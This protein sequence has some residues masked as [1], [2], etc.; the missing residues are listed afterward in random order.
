MSTIIFGYEIL[1]SLLH[2]FKTTYIMSSCGYFKFPLSR[3]HINLYNSFSPVK[4]L[5]TISRFL[6]SPYF[7]RLQTVGT[8][9]VSIRRNKTLIVYWF[10]V[11]Q[12]GGIMINFRQF[13]NSVKFEHKNLSSTSLDFKLSWIARWR[14]AFSLESIFSSIL[15]QQE[16]CIL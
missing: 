11:I 2:Q 7:K 5:S 6:H 3:L 9:S 1:K 4:P 10:T 8:S 15:R 14:W 16:N 13:K 12:K